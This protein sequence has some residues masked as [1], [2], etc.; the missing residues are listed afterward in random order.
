LQSAQQQ[1]QYRQASKLFLKQQLGDVAHIYG[2]SDPFQQVSE[3]SKATVPSHKHIML[4]SLKR[5]KTW[6]A[7]SITST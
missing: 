3:D 1:Q 4:V 7:S 5:L 6:V 2:R